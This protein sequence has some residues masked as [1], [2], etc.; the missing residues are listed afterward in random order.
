M[1][2]G[3]YTALFGLSFVKF[4]FAPLGG[5]ALGFSFIETYL[6]CTLGAFTMASVS[7]FL[8]EYFLIRA[9]KKRAKDYR[10]SI[11]SG[12]E[13]PMK[14]DFTFTN[15][16]IV[17]IKR[18]FGIYGICLWAPLFLSIPLGTIVSAKFYRKKKK[19]FPLIA[20]GVFLNGF[21]ITS[22]VYIHEIVG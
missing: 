1:S 17:K 6:S 5:V 9:Q 7:Y 12:M 3:G 15:K 22:I 8:S 18:T 11:E 16:M 20:F 10:K 13:F 2:W 21:V 14:K 4:M 19:C